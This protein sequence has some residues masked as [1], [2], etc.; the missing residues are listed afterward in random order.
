MIP[1]YFDEHPK[2]EGVPIT[3][4]SILRMRVK[5]GE[6]PWADIRLESKAQSNRS[7]DASCQKVLAFPGT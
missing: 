6:L 4:H 2:G 5:K 3:P 1:H 7:F